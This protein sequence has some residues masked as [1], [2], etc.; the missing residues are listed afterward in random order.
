M[1]S[2]YNLSRR[3]LIETYYKNNIHGVAVLTSLRNRLYPD[4][5]VWDL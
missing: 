3:E 4:R 2:R 1:M 5:L